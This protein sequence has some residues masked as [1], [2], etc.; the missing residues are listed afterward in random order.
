MTIRV[1]TLSLLLVLAAMTPA[2]AGDDFQPFWTKFTAALKADDQA[3][4]KALVRFPTLYQGEEVG[5]DRF[6][7]VY[8]GLFTAKNRACLAKAKPLLQENGDGQKSYF[9]F[10]SKMVW[11]FD[12]IAGDWRYAEIG[13]DD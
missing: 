5:A 11:V 4:V 10:C 13:P 8:K 1:A 12:R 7:E 9:A 3:A 6:A 2:A